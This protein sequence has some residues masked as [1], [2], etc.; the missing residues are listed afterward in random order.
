MHPQRLLLL[1][2]SART[3]VL[4]VEA[5]GIRRSCQRPPDGEQHRLR[6]VLLQSSLNLVSPLLTPPINLTLGIE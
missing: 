1:P 3:S 2:R 5:P 4:A 6:E